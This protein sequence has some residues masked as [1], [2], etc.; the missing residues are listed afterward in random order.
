MNSGISKYNIDIDKI[1]N[2]LQEYIYKLESL[3]N[4]QIPKDANVIDAYK[5]GLINESGRDRII[6]SKSFFKRNVYLKQE[7]SILLGN[8]Q[9]NEEHANWIV[10]EW[11]GIKGNKKLEYED[12]LFAIDNDKGVKLNKI[13]SLSK[14]ASFVNPSKYI[15]Y[16]ARVA[17]SMN[18]IMLKTGASNIFFPMPQSRNSKLNAFNI[19]VLIRL[20]N[21]EKYRINEVREIHEK[22]ISQRDRYLFINEEDAYLTMCEIAKNLSINLYNEKDEGYDKPYYAEMLLFS[23]ADTEI[24]RDITTSLKLKMI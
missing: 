6:N 14:I 16:D 5:I 22:F 11:G 21:N 13:A 15:I 12:F 3:Y 19:E 8:I 4:W 1:A 10:R 24:L 18:W 20:L 23:I 17:Y 9:I 7:I 2:Y